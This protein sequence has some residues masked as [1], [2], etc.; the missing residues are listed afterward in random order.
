MGDQIF[1]LKDKHEQRCGVGKRLWQAE[2]TKI[3]EKNARGQWIM[4]LERQFG[5]K[6]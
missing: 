4:E 5:T 3:L 2:I 6:S 1:S